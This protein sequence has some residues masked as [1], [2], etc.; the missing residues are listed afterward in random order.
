MLTTHMIE[1]KKPKIFISHKTEDKPFVE[2][3]VDLIEHIIGTDSDNIFCSSI[4][5]YDIKP[6][7][8]ILS[9]LKRQFEENDVLF[10]IV[11]SPRY[12]QSPIC[13]NEMGA[14][15]V[16]GSNFFSFLTSDCKFSNLKGVIDGKY[17]SIKVNDSLDMVMSKL[18]SF[19]DYLLETFNLNKEKFNN[20]RW[21]LKRNEFIAR[22]CHI[23]Y[24]TPKENAIVQEV[25]IPQPTADIVAELVSKNPYVISISNRGSGT[26]KNL[27]LQLDE[28]CNGMLISGLDNFP[29]DYLKPDRHVSLNVYP[30]LGDPQKFKLYFEWEEKGVKFYSEDIITI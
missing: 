11:H 13:M 17:M 14:A 24:D 23:E 10:I 27:H 9:E 15:W 12:Y 8:D 2:E 26:S 19:K 20:T 7:K 29:L 1:K 18:N 28:K 16:L 6:G 30:C 21:E 22:S 4:G 25:T 3:L 5:G